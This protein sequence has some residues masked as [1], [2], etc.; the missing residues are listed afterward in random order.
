MLQDGCRD[1]ITLVVSNVV[2]DVAVTSWTCHRNCVP[3]KT[4]YCFIDSR[5][6]RQRKC[7][8]YI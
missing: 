3:A 8:S 7:Y 4:H 1:S 2:I 5:A 6:E